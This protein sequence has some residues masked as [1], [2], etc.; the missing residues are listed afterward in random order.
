MV[1]VGSGLAAVFAQE[2]EALA[3]FLR[4]RCGNDDEADD[5]LQELWL[6]VDGVPS[7][8]IGNGR[9]YLFRMANNLVLDQ[10]RSRMRAMKRDR[11]WLGDA[12][13]AP[14]MRPDPAPLA[15]TAI[16]ASQEAEILRRAIEELPPGARHALRL[17]R[18][19][20]RSQSEIAAIMGISRSGV[21]KH[22]ATAMKNLRQALY[23]CGAFDPVTSRE[24]K[25]VAGGL[26]REGE[27]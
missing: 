14:D 9:A 27:I 20:E 23:D 13:T 2:K 8:P 26:P 21:E 16:A 11:A 7:G 15:D 1:P 3:R 17:Y 18:F 24:V 10:R 4:A 22:L 19:E 25:S 6:K 5:M 12:D